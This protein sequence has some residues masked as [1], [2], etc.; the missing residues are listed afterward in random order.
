MK[1]KVAVIDQRYGLEVNGGSEFYAR[2]IAEQLNKKYD[3]EVLTSCCI[4][5]VRYYNHYKAGVEEINGVK[6][7]RFPT[8]H[9]RIPK[10]FTP[11]DIYMQEHPD[12][13]ASKS[14]EWIEQMGPYVPSLIDYVGKHQDEFAAIFV[15]TYL[16]YP[17]IKSI[18]RAPEKAVFIPTAHPEP[19]IHFDMYKPVFNSPKAY[20]F[21]TE[22]ERQLVHGIFKNSHIPSV[23][24]GVGVDVPGTPSEEVFREK[25]GIKDDYIIYV[26]RIDDGKGCS[27]LFNYFLEYKKRNPGNLKLVLMG[28]AVIPVPKNPD[29]ISLGFVSEEDKFHGI[30]GA[31][32]LVLPSRFES[33][34]IVIL[35]AMTLGRPVIVNGTCDVTKGHCTRSNAGLYY[36]D[37]FE[38]EGAVNYL[39]THPEEYEVMSENAKAYVNKYFRWDVIMEKF[40]RVIAYVDGEIDHLED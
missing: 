30:A 40:D 23:C 37:Y 34:S 27:Q 13:P 3:V 8:E 38:F 39:L 17:A 1:K 36:K 11:L 12:A 16:Y 6:V 14:D 28:K 7:H 2:E 20:V 9:E 35:E 22:E 21:L 32:A 5:Y 24:C 15:I 31:K 19:F 18:L 25:F 10:L 29:I 4:E 33:L 26:G